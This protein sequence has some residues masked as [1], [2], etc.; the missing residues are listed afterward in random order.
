MFQPHPQVGLLNIVLRW[1][2]LPPQMWLTSVKEVLPSIA[3]MNIWAR[4]G[5]DMIIFL[6]GLEAIEL[7]LKDH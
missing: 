1:L 3:I 4:L 7:E 2:G 6:A 5:F